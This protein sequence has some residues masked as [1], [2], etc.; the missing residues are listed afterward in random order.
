MKKIIL[1]IIVSIIWQRVSSQVGIGTITPSESAQL[2]VS[3]SSKGFLP[4][5]VALIATN[6]TT[7]ISSPATGLLVYNTNV[8]GISPNNVVPGYYYYDGSSWQRFNIE[9]AGSRGQRMEVFTVT[10]TFSVPTGVNSVV[11][12]LWGAGGGGTPGT[13]GLRGSWGK[14]S[15]TVTPGTNYTVTVGVGGSSSISGQAGCGSA[16]EFAG[17][18]ARGGWG[19]NQ[20]S[21]ATGSNA[22][23]ACNSQYDRTTC[24]FP[25]GSTLGYGAGGSNTPTAGANGLVIIYY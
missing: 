25:P 20:N 11:V 23:L 3:S 5:R 9:P 21:C 6:L 24:N 4:P 22:V 19:A 17:Y 16:S 8:A 18:Y 10:S 15:V 7:P 1:I 12:E 14:Q 13:A 2:E